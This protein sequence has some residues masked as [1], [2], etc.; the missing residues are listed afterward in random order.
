MFPASSAFTVL[1]SL[2]EP[3]HLVMSCSPCSQWLPWPGSP[4][5]PARAGDGLDAAA[6]EQHQVGGAV[7]AGHAGL[8]T[9]ADVIPVVAGLGAARPARVVHGAMFTL[10]GWRERGGA[11]SS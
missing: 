2:E 6:L 7:A 10:G 1:D 11:S 5:S 8:V 4:G 9:R 3:E